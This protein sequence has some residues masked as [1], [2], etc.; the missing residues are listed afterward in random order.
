MY[1]AEA[2]FDGCYSMGSGPFPEAAIQSMVDA[3]FADCPDAGQLANPL[4]WTASGEYWAPLDSAGMVVGQV[5]DQT[6]T[7]LNLGTYEYP[8][9]P[10]EPATP[11]T[12]DASFSFIAACGLVALFALGY[13]GGH[14]R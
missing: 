6:G 5:W 11:A 13:I 10:P 4:S 14:Q 2:E 8:W 1:S 7:P 3:R 9:I 12:P